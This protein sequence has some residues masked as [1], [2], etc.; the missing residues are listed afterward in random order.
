MGYRLDIID[1]TFLENYMHMYENI[2]VLQKYVLKFLG[3]KYHGVSF[4]CK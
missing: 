4:T 1:V 3:L 2:L